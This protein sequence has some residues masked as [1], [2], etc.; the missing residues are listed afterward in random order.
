MPLNSTSRDVLIPLVNAAYNGKN[1]RGQQMDDYTAK[2]GQLPTET[3]RSILRSLDRAERNP[4][5]RSLASQFSHRNT[6]SPASIERFAALMEQE[7]FRV[8]DLLAEYG[9]HPDVIAKADA[10]AGVLIFEDEHGSLTD[11]QRHRLA[12]IL[13]VAGWAAD[14]GTSTLKK[15]EHGNYS[16]INEDALRS[17]LIADHPEEDFHR[18]MKEMCSGQQYSRFFELVESVSGN[19]KPLLSGVL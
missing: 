4:E 12:M 3:L 16:L 17:Y 19:N 1:S 18:L 9:V 10:I 15:G 5:I 11:V 14:I 7:F 2:I 6:S 8:H 13:A